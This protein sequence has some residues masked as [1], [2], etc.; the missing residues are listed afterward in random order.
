[1]AGRLLSLLEK[2]TSHN[3]LFVLFAAPSF[4]VLVL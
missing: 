1:M 3:A 2:V 4:Q